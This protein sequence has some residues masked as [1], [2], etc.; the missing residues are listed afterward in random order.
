M[1]TIDIHTHMFG[2]GWLDMIKQHGAPA[3]EIADMEDRR[4]YLVEYGTPACALEVEAFDYDKRVEM[5]DRLGIDISIVSL[6]SPNVHFGDEAISVATAR[7]AN[8][9]MAAGQTAYPD[10]IRFFATLPWEYPE[11]AAIELGRA[12]KL[13][14]VGV[15]T[16]ANI[17]EKFLN[18]PLFDP[19]WAD[20][21]KRDLPVLIHPTVP[22]GAEKMDLGTYRLLGPV[23]FMF[24]TSLALSRMILDGFFDRFPK[25][26]V[27]AS[28][29]GG[30]LPYVSKR[31]DLFFEQGGFDKKITDLPSTYLERIYYD[32][33]IY[34]ADGLQSLINLAGPDRIMFG[35]D[36]PHAADIPVLKQLV[37]DLPADQTA[38]ILGQAAQNIFNI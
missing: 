13:G 11:L 2:D 17:R 35:T 25:L 9:E 8:D 4:N 3:Y 15:M 6:T 23:G 31:M 18:D 37:E 36:Y 29:A 12:V 33:I 32:S 5:M 30:Y 20:I 24:D 16:L 22:L 26:K 28:H 14:A 7:I 19:I 1:P 34:Q 38:K 27:I 10:R 21:E